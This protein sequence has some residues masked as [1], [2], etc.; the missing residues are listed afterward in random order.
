M[1]LSSQ[2]NSTKREKQCP[3]T[4]EQQRPRKTYQAPEVTAHGTIQEITRASTGPTPADAFF[5]F[6][7]S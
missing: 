6:Q 4:P 2:P 7:V 1:N 5:G 3:D